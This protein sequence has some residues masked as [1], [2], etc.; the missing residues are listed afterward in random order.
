LR[1]ER[2]PYEE[3]NLQKGGVLRPHI[4]THKPDNNRFVCAN[5]LTNQQKLTEV[6]LPQTVYLLDLPPPFDYGQQGWKRPR[7]FNDFEGSNP[8]EM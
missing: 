7:D 5:P 1:T 3:P 6:N 8:E 2:F 4:L